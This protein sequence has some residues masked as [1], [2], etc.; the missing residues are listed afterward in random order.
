MR[1]DLSHSHGHEHEHE[2]EP[3]LGLPEALPASEK[4]L[5]Q[6]APVWTSVAR[7]VFHLRK[8][9]VYFLAMIALRVF[10]V[11]TDP[12][13]SDPMRAALASVVW[14]GGIAAFAMIV[15]AVMAYVVGRT[16]LYTI[17]NKRV[18]MRIGMVLSLTYNLP[19]RTIAEAAVRRGAG[20][21]GDIALTLA[22]SDKIA[23]LH[24]W[25]HAKPWHYA[26][27]EPMLRCLRQVDEVSRILKDAWLTHQSMGQQGTQGQQDATVVSSNAASGSSAADTRHSGMQTA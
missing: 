21:T 14:L 2:F 13:V 16:T 12:A 8:L 11:M 4:V 5:W 3:Q 10:F 7:D 9:A 17:T 18:V 27:P 23:Y 20:S 6:G 25:P 26:K 15:L 24:L 22:T 19:L 1:A